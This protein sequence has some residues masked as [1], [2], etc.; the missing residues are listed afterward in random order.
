[1]D[2]ERLADELAAH[3]AARPALELPPDGRATAAVL[4]P[5]FPD[6]ALGLC[7]LLTVRTQTVRDHKGQ[8]SFPG[9]VHEADD[10]DLG[11]TALRE[12]EEELALPREAVR[13]V[14][15]LNDTPV[16]TGYLIRPFVGLLRARPAVRPSPEEIELVLWPSLRALA[17]PGACRWRPVHV[18]DLTVDSWTFDVDGHMVWGATARMLVELLERLKP[19]L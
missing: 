8:V 6:P 15:R 17:A 10:A 4:A 7:T 13:L 19:L 3:L 12:T 9:G 16:L 11:A 18:G 2:F 1:M 5:L 14:G